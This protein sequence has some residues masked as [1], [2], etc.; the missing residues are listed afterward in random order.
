MATRQQK[1][2]AAAPRG[3]GG[4]SRIV[5]ATVVAIVAIGAVVAAVILASTS[6]SKQA[7]AGGSAL[8]K[9]A[10]SM[11]AGLVALPGVA[12]RPGAPTM[13]LYEDFQCPSCGAFEKALGS[14]V[15]TLGKAG[16]VKLVYHV[17]TFLDDNLQN[18]SSTRAAN[19]A[20]CAADQD[21]FL[22]YHNATYAG[23]PAQ[24]GAGYTDAQL[25]QFAQTAG[26]TGAGLTTWQSCYSSR[27]HNQYIK[28][29]QTQATKDGIN[30]TPTVKL[31][32]KPLDLTGMTPQS[33]GK[34][35]ADATK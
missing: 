33:L 30:Q 1:I 10:P 27:A 8:P 19:A 35:V 21:K 14:E 23:Q 11:G 25:R 31:N 29:V 24:E 7:V 26:I 3:R 15:T 17:L 6:Q 22:P 32:G 20:M 18:D 16:R 28:S 13:D 4:P 5:I 34:A 2:A 9:G 12:L